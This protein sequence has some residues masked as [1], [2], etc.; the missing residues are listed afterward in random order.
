MRQALSHG[1]GSTPHL[2]A[3]SEPLNTMKA[4]IQGAKHEQSRSVKC[5][6]KFNYHMLKQHVREREEL[7]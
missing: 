7:P 2:F 6:V 1:C 3:S 5:T 4:C